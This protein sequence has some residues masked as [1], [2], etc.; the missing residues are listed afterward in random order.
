MTPRY[1]FL[2]NGRI[3]TRNR[4][5][6]QGI[7]KENFRRWK[8]IDRIFLISD[9]LSAA[10]FLVH[11]FGLSPELYYRNIGAIRAIL[12]AH[13]LNMDF[14]HLHYI[15]GRGIKIEAYQ[16]RWVAFTNFHFNPHAKNG[17][18]ETPFQAIADLYRFQ[19]YNHQK[20]FIL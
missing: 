17:I 7:G 16:G 2:H 18:G 19:Y 15:A 5:L 6:I 13:E 20:T 12:H 3:E 4:N 8:G 14:W 9:M 10:D 1:F 11:V